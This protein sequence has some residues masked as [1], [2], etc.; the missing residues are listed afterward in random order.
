[1]Q[2]AEAEVV[3][4]SDDDS[5][6]AD[7]AM[8]TL[9]NP[10]YKEGSKKLD[11]SFLVLSDNTQRK[12]LEEAGFV[13]IQEAN[14]KVSQTATVVSSQP[15]KCSLVFTDPGGRVAPGPQARSG[16]AFR[17]DDVEQRHRGYV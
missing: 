10:L 17:T 1:M 5:I 9:W 13:D 2:S 4:R 6:P 12:S 8:T 11:M 3:I 16:R 15:R 14:Y 7:S